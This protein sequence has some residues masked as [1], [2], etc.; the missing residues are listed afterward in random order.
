MATLQDYLGITALRDAWPKWKANVVAVNNQVI[1]HIA[2]SADKHAAQD[3][4]Y[5]GDFAG[6]TEVK[7]ALDQAKTEIDTIVVNASIDPEVAFARD[8]AVKSKVFGSLDAR[9]EESEQE[10]V[11]DKAETTL[12]FNSEK[13][14]E[15]SPIPIPANSEVSWSGQ[16]FIQDNIVT[17]NGCQYIVMVNEAKKPY[18]WKRVLATSVWTSFDLS[19]IAGNPLVSPTAGDLHNVYVLAIDADGYIHL[20]GNMHNNALRYIQST[21]P[22]DIT[23]WSAELMVGSEESSVSYPQFFKLPNNKLLFLYR[24]GGSGNGNTYLNIYN[25]VTKA[26][27]RQAFI[28][29]GVTTGVNAY[30]N[31]A[32]VDW[33]TGSIQL[34]YVWRGTGNASTNNDICYAKSEDEG[35]TWQKSNGDAYTLPITQSTGEI[36]HDTASSGSGVVNQC[37]FEVDSDGIPHGAFWLYDANGYT[38]MHHFYYKDG[39]WLNEQVTNWTYRLETDVS[40]LGG[41]IG[42]P[43]VVCTKDGRTFLVYRHNIENLG[44]LRMLEITIGQEKRDFSILDL[45]LYDYEF[46]FDTNLMKTEN[47]LVSVIAPCNSYGA[48]TPTFYNENNWNNQFVG[49][50]TIDMYNVNEIIKGGIKL[51]TIRHLCDSIF[52]LAENTTATVLTDMTSPLV[53]TANN[54]LLYSD[55][56]KNLSVLYRLTARADQVSGSGFVIGLAERDGDS[57]AVAKDVPLLPFESTLNLIKSTPWIPIKALNNNEPFFLSLAGLVDSA[58]EGRVTLSNIELG[59]LD[60]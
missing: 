23:A 30:T 29:D 27:S 18:I 17:Y 2:G 41:Q 21:N 32:G 35:V 56:R 55:R 40:I 7:A 13:I 24:E 33:E 52:T 42:R 1:A 47:K 59:Y 51:P 34:M 48:I 8:S 44:T 6:K 60:F 49:V 10:R 45:E 11:T 28:F 9:L 22:E 4:T 36:V 31:H 54:V 16:S 46:S 39:A 14:L 19:T 26:W 37:G 58:S 3:I 20:S 43:S 15:F 38:Q 53:A 57:S 12:R 50:L 25:T 5:T